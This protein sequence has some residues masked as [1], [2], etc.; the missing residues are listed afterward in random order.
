MPAETAIVGTSRTE[1]SHEEFLDNMKN[2]V[3][4][5]SRIPPSDETWMPFSR[6]LYYVPG[7]ASDPG[8][9]SDLKRRL[10]EIDTRCGSKGNRVWYCATS[11]GLFEQ[12]AEGVG[13]SGLMDTSGWH[14]LVVEK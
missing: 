1:C 5:H 14:R 3:R 13:K 7:D 11:P 2:A 10:D 4:E 8:F 12:I 9:F 6:D